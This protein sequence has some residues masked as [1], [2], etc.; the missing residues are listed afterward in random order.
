MVAFLKGVYGRAK[1]V[2]KFLMS[3][4]P[5]LKHTWNTMVA[6]V[7]GYALEHSVRGHGRRVSEP[8]HPCFATTLNLPV[9][10][11]QPHPDPKYALHTAVRLGVAA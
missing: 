8:H 2:D 1:E 6:F 4:Q 11:R 5:A 7:L 3:Q 10:E 9:V